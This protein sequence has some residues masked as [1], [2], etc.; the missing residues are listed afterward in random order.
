MSSLAPPLERIGPISIPVLISADCTTEFQLELWIYGGGR[1]HVLSL[2]NPSRQASPLVRIESACTFAHLYRSRLCDC[3]YQL[4][5]A[6]RRIAAERH[7]LLI[8]ALDQH[9][10]GVGLRNHLLVY[11]EEQTTGCDTV[12]AHEKLGLPEDAREYGD[13]VNI[14]KHHNAT[15][16]RLLTNNPRRIRALQE[17]DSGVEREALIAEF[18]QYNRRELVVKQRKLGHLL[19]LERC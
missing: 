15:S 18:D 17:W 14:L 16:I 5:E 3:E 6:V 10:R 8:Y 19:N 12:E 4:R 13:V 7:G 1:Y 11:R 2:G 9:G